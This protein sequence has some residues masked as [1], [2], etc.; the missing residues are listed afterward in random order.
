MNKG[1]PTF[2]RFWNNRCEPCDLTSSVISRYNTISIDYPEMF[3]SPQRQQEM[4]KSI[5]ELVNSD[6]NVIITTHS[7]NIAQTLNDIC[8]LNIHPDKEALMEKYGFTDKQLISFE[9][10]SVYSVD[11]IFEDGELKKVINKVELEEDWFTFQCFIDYLR[12]ALDFSRAVRDTDEES[13][14]ISNEQ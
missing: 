11:N 3:L 8:K 14:E 13:E 1:N 5:V 9:D 4:V 7:D 12:S 2:Y 6:K 10:I